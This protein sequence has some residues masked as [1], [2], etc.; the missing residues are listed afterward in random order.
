MMI[1]ISTL[2]VVIAPDH[3]L[4]ARHRTKHFRSMITF[5]PQDNSMRK[6][7]RFLQF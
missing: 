6:V 3:L 5:N 7:A 2:T 1:V 4:Y